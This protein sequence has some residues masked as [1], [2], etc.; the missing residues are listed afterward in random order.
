MRSRPGT[1]LRKWGM[2]IRDERQAKVDVHFSRRISTMKSDLRV[3]LESFLDGFTG[4]NLLYKAKHPGIP[5]RL[6][7]LDEDPECESEQD[8]DTKRP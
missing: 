6:L 4:G 7:I 2:I 8:P 5:D 1:S 3:A